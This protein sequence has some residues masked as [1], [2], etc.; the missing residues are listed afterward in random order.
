MRQDRASSNVNTLALHDSSAKGVIMNKKEFEA[1]LK[2]QAEIA[3]K[4]TDEKLVQELAKI[5]KL[6]QSDI[7][8]ILPERAD[9]EKFARLKAILDAETTKNNKQAQFLDNIQELGG[10]LFKLLNVVL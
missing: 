1:F 9:K 5:T 3:K 8:K 2:K 6:T 7:D 10:M 4:A